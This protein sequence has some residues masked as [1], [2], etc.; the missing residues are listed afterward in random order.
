MSLCI[1]IRESPKIQVHGI[2]GARGSKVV[3]G[4]VS[5]RCLVPF[6]ALYTHTETHVLDA[7]PDHSSVDLDRSYR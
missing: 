1:P 7:Y 4:H 3:T 6:H 5:Q 2:M